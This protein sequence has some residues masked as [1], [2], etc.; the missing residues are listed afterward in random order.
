MEDEKI[1]E[2]FF[3]RSE[4]AIKEL[5]GKYGHQCHRL[6]YNI[7]K[8]ALDA[9]ECVS[10][11]YFGTWNA[12][13]PQRPRSL[14]AFVCRLVRNFSL[15][16]YRANNA[17]KRNSVYDLALDEIEYTLADPVGVEDILEARDLARILEEFLD[18]L[19]TE[20]RVIFLG[21]YWFADSYAQIA[22]QVGMTQ[23]NVSVRLTRI[24]KD[25]R[26]YLRK[27]GVAL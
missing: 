1:I 24:R 3:A 20:N 16:R 4:F 27:E 12:I 19:S 17:L 15:T 13:P 8:N 22:A 7:L 18:T 5:D 25:L 21:R 6:S 26:G 14:P 2:L 11:A 10:D 9:E 23:K